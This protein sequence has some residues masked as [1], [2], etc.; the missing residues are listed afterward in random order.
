MGMRMR[1]LLCDAEVSWLDLRPAGT[2][3]R[4]RDRD[5]EEKL[6]IN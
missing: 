6:K 5:A 4:D 3:D 2:G 1:G